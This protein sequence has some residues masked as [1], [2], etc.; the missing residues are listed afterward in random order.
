[1]NMK[2]ISLM[3]IA[4]S[5][6]LSSCANLDLNPLS[7]GSS[8][9]W[10][11]DATEIEMSLNDLWRADFFPIDD[12]D[13]DD[14]WMNRNGSNVVTLG[15]IT[16]QWS[17]ASGRWTALY[18]GIT[19]S[20]KIIA[21]LEEG[22]AKGLSD[23]L[24]KQ[25]LGEAYFMQGFA[26]GE[27]ATYFGDVVL[28]KEAI[29]LDEAYVAKQSPRS[30][31]FKYCYECLDKAAGFLPATRSGQQRPTSG[32]ALGFKARFA[33]VNQDWQTAVSACEAIMSSG[34]YSL[35]PNYKDLFTA[36]SSPEL[37]FYFQGNLTQKKGVGK[38][39][40]VKDLV[41]RKI[42]GYSNQGPSYELFV[43]YPCIDGLR[44]D[45]SPLFDSKDPF[46]NRDPRM[47]YTIQPFM[48][49]YSEDFEAYQQARIDGTLPEKFP[50]YIT[51]GYEYNNSPYANRVFEV[52]SGNLVVNTDSKASNQH[53]VYTGLQLRKFV[54]DSWADYNSYNSVGDNV[55][56]YL[57]YAEIL[58][59]YI[60]AKNELGS[61]TQADLDKSI[62]L[63]RAR[64]YAGTGIDYPKIT[65]A[66][67]DELRQ[68]IRNERRIELCFEGHRYRDML[69]WKLAEYAF[70]RPK[71]YLPRAWSGNANWNGSVEDS[72]VS[73]S[74][75]FKSILKNWDDGNFPLGGDIVFDENG[76]PDLS[77]Q[78]AH[79]YITAFYARGFDKNKNYL[80]PIPADDILVNPSLIQNPGY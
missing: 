39:S 1:M 49:K 50:D 36:T 69:R 2:K 4:I 22:S 79:G 21:A 17:T 71:Y 11:H 13:W 67:Q 23:A 56:P 7:Y 44:I 37:M 65:V 16:S 74:D 10:Y 26:Y 20:Q 75:E 68:T 25:Y 57:R 77:N 45:K 47:A 52:K 58:L 60:E 53:S 61:V 59:S 63:V 33:L 18:K 9:N 34:V 6:V 51:L 29:T 31:V 5:F 70:A 14:D 12:L 3:A 72:N 42:G 64:A 35:H 41:I 48:S 15:T 73:L 43:S 62:N 76:L 19:R 30:E 66:S 27:L 8:E 54:K 46:K 80:W 24:V 78:E 38:F 55:Y 32:A 28:N 40:N